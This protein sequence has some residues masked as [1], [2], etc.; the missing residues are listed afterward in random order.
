MANT[1]IM[2]TTAT[3]ISKNRS[4]GPPASVLLFWRCEGTSFDGTHDFSAGDTTVTLVSAAAI[5]TDAV[6]SGTN[7]LDIPTSYDR[8][9]LDIS[10]NDIIDP[11]SGVVGFWWKPN[12]Y[13]DGLYIWRAFEDVNNYISLETV[14]TDEIR[15]Y[16]KEDV[17]GGQTI[18][19]STANLTAQWY[20]VQYAW[21][22]DSNSHTLK[23]WDS[24]G[25]P[26]INTTENESISPV[27]FG[28]EIMY[29]GNTTASNADMYYDLIISS[30][31]PSEDLHAYS[32]YTSYTDF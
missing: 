23:I 27:S 30:D 9:E 26:V 32:G 28:T 12:S 14:G 5:N 31:D 8:A 19:T 29:I 1:S 3:I 13:V 10:S 24:G 4:S 2:D 22:T 21:D 15:A 7:G 20:W 25:T 18:I 11:V 17:G 6:Y 16:Y